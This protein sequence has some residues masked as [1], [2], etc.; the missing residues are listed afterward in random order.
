ML[1]WAAIIPGIREKIFFNIRMTRR[2]CA[3]YNRYTFKGGILEKACE[4]RASIL[5]AVALS[6]VC[7][8]AHACN[9]GSVR[10]AAL[11]AKRDVHRL[12]LFA[13]KDDK[14]ADEQYSRLEK[15]FESTGGNLNL[16]LERINADD[17]A[18]NWRTYGI[19]SAPPSLPATALI[20]M[21]PSPKRIFIINHWEPAPTDEDLARLQTSPARDAIKATVVDKWAALLYSPGRDRER[22]HASL[23]SWPLLN[24]GIVTVR[25]G[26]LNPD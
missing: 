20:G 18:T 23:P 9:T 12:C 2:C 15:W 11:S 26:K 22:E 5:F 17:P 19:P 6:T 7:A 16:V 24:N 4:K 13:N 1:L 14:S 25:P 8:A 10:D 21:F 3:R